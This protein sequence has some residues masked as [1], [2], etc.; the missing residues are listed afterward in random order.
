MQGLQNCHGRIS[1][2]KYKLL[3]HG[4]P[5][6]LL[7]LNG[8]SGPSSNRRWIADAIHA[9]EELRTTG[10]FKDG[11]QVVVEPLTSLLLYPDSREEGRTVQ[12][13]QHLF[14]F[15]ACLVM[16]ASEVNRCGILNPSC[17]SFSTLKGSI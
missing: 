15:H 14:A 1:R 10:A 8:E 12:L 11:E 9:D 17:C 5:T 16:I 3:E 2:E 7:C 13:A 6:F 4:A